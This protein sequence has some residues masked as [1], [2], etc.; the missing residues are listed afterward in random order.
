MVYFTDLATF[1]YHSGPFS[2]DEWECPLL[3]VGWLEKEFAFDKGP[4]PTWLIDR[5]S[6]I[7][8]STKAQ[9]LQWAFRGLH[10]CTLCEKHTM[11]TDSHINLFVPG[12]DCVYVAPGRIDHYILEHAYKPPQVFVEAIAKC[13]D[14]KSDEYLKALTSVNANQVPPLFRDLS[15]KNTN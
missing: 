4:S 1:D 10:S 13:I 14:P 7:R 6:S 3:S 15:S 11:L 2:C 8:I 9:F 12:V 5:I